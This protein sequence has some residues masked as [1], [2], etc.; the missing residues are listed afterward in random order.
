MAA[1][2]WYSLSCGNTIRMAV[3]SDASI[4]PGPVKSLISS[5][6]RPSRLWLLPLVFVFLLTTIKNNGALFSS[7]HPFFQAFSFLS[8]P[9]EGSIHFLIAAFVRVTLFSLPFVI[10]TIAELRKRSFSNTTI[11]RLSHS[12]GFKYADVFYFLI[13]ILLR[14]FSQLTVFITLGLATISSSFA[15]LLRNAYA[16]IFS[17]YLSLVS[18]L[19]I[20]IFV[21]L[22]DDFIKFYSHRMC[23]K[24]PFLWD[25]HEFHHSAT[26]MTILNL[27]RN[28]PFERLLPGLLFLP[29]TSL[30]SIALVES[31]S[32]GGYVATSLYLFDFVMLQIFSYMGH[33]SFLLLYPKPLSYLYMSPG[34]HW[35]HHSES[36]LHWDTNFGE[37]YPF[38]DKL[39]GSFADNSRVSEVQSFGV[40][41]GSEY[42]SRNPLYSFCVIPIKRIFSRLAVNR[43]P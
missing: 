9:S 5:T 7:H 8:S 41:D 31:I 12:K 20:L 43:C 32:R 36:K 16:S 14:S 29:I 4:Y 23:H 27:Q 6:A 33:S 38:W 39:F 35:I 34:L 17:H 10:V 11:G 21:M 25:F 26:E 13:N 30:T 15:D 24:I 2:K 42:N 37:K 1:R 22:I 18:P 3:H 19:V 40:I 28:L